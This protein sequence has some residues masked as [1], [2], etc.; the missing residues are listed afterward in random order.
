MNKQE[1]KIYSQ[2]IE[3]AFIQ[4]NEKSRLIPDENKL[5]TQLH[6]IWINV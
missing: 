6:P 3:N 2:N 1:V 4:F 5:L